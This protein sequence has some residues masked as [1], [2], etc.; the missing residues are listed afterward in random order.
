LDKEKGPLRGLIENPNK[1]RLLE[2]L[3]NQGKLLG[4]L[5]MFNTFA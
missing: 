2:I 1:W 5:K 3:I 4:K